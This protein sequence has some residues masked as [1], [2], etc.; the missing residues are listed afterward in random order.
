MENLTAG[1]GSQ[2]HFGRVRV[3]VMRA[4]VKKGVL[5]V[6]LSLRSPDHQQIVDLAQGQTVVVPG[7]G[8]ITVTGVHRR[9]SADGRESVDLAWEPVG[10]AD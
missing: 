9:S 2:P 7:E 1:Q 3:G 4:G 10:P 8:S 5:T 6:R